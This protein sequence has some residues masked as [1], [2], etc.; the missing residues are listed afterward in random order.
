M[1]GKH[2]DIFISCKNVRK[3]QILQNKKAF[4]RNKGQTYKPNSDQSIF[5]LNFRLFFCQLPER[6]KSADVIINAGKN[7]IKIEKR[8]KHSKMVKKPFAIHTYAIHIGNHCKVKSTLFLNITKQ[9]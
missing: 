4:G 9:M 7:K 1:A 2:D 3:K 8:D 6:K 5:L